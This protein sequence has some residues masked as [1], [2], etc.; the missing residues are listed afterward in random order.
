MIDFSFV[1]FMHKDSHTFIKQ[2]RNCYLLIKCVVSSVEVWRKK[3]KHG[4]EILTS[5]TEYF[6][7]LT[8]R[9]KCSKTTLKWFNSHSSIRSLGHHISNIPKKFIFL[10]TNFKVRFDVIISNNY[11][12]LF[13]VFAGSSNRKTKAPSSNST[14]ETFSEADDIIQEKTMDMT[15]INTAYC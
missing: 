8:F 1:P 2:P 7:Y 10:R 4:N 11:F 13:C 14:N 12:I 3:G 6:P 15:Q 5:V 9:R